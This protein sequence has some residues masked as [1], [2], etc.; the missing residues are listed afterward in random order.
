MRTIDVL[1]TFQVNPQYSPS[2]QCK[3]EDIVSNL[4][5]NEVRRNIKL[6]PD[7][8][9]VEDGESSFNAAL[10]KPGGDVALLHIQRRIARWCVLEP[11][12]L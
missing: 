9:N 2:C 1:R 8:F 12:P 3:H 11:I 10:S 7:S 6:E 4:T 5:S